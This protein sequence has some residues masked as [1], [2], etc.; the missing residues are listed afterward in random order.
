ML[1]RIGYACINTSLK[2]K[3][4]SDCRLNSVYK[5]GINYLRDK[6]INNLKLTKEILN[7]NINNGIFMYRV[8]S[9][10]LPLVTHPDLLNDFKWRWT[11]DE[12]ILKLMEDVKDIVKKNNIR[13]S[14]HPDQFTVINSLNEKVVENSIINLQ[15][16]YE[17]L[18]R[19]GGTDMIIHTGG[20]YGNKSAAMERFIK[21]Y[22]SLDNNIKKYLRLENDDKSYTLADVLYINSKT[23]VPVVLDIHHH[24][25]NNNKEMDIKKEINKV[26]DSWTETELIPK[27]HISSGKEGKYDK[28]HHDYIKEEDMMSLLDLMENIDF[29]LMVEA[30]MKE[31]AVL[32]I[33]DF[34]NLK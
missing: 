17:V 19:L 20:V 2:P 33:K 21:T 25:C 31:K 10:L 11:E 12:D 22:N 34:L 4:F 28:R 13:L 16:H 32:K 8:T 18:S 29:D 5:Y 27:L 1:K 26:V 9:K 23:S 30:K 7:W 6:I 15:Y 14:M 24:V 3:K